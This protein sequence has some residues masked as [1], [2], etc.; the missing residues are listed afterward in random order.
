MKKSNTRVD[1]LMVDQ[2]LVDTRQKAQALLMAGDVFIGDTRI[3]KPGSLVPEDSIVVLKRHP[4]YVSR[5]G[6]KL[7][8]A[9]EKFEV[10]FEDTVVLD[11]GAS[12]GGFTDCMLKH[13]AKRVFA[14]DVGHGQLDAGL[15]KDHRVVVMERLNARYPFTLPLPVD[16]IIIDVSFIS[17][18]KILPTVKDLL[19]C[20][21]TILALVKPQFE[22]ERHLV[23]SG[24]IVRNPLT[25]GKVLGTIILW[26]ID[27]GFRIRDLTSLSIMGQGGN[28]EFFLRLSLRLD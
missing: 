12:T 25:H 24:G 6:L 5:G 10:D 22:T 21:G 1:R 14:V 28:R 17:L 26:A 4:L 27:N 18:T 8:Q 19:K 13:G 23:G 15:R 7:A 9:I 3:T 16:F 20:G 11:V 2:G